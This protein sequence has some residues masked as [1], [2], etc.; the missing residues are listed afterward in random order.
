[1]VCFSGQSCTY[2]YNLICLQIWIVTVMMA[3]FI[4]MMI[5]MVHDQLFM[6][7]MILTMLFIPECFFLGPELGLEQ[8]PVSQPNIPICDRMVASKKW[9]TSLLWA[10]HENGALVSPHDYES[11][12]GGS[13]I[14]LSFTLC[15]HII[16]GPNV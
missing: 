1:M 7:R 6:L 5:P 2:V 12:F 9:Q 8:W 15:R 4:V 13:T 11:A 14:Q 10:Y 16:S 3:K